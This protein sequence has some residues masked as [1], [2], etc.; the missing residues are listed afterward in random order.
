M[1]GMPLNLYAISLALK[2]ILELNNTAGLIKNVTEW[3]KR[4]MKED[5][6]FNQR[7]GSSHWNYSKILE[8]KKDKKKKKREKEIKTGRKENERN[9]G[10]EEGK[11]EEREEERSKGKRKKKEG[12]KKLKK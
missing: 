2:Q 10:K 4:R 12:K 6:K 11:N 9:K 3:L 5:Q 8:N 1:E 7:A